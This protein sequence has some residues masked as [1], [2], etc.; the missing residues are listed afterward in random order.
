MRS[1]TLCRSAARR[2]SGVLILV[3]AFVAGGTTTSWAQVMIDFDTNGP[4]DGIQLADWFDFFGFEP[5]L[6]ATWDVVPNN[7]NPANGSLAL[8]TNSNGNQLIVQFS[9]V[10]I[11]KS[12]I[13]ESANPQVQVTI[14]WNDNDPTGV[15]LRA[16][17][18]T[19]G[20]DGEPQNFYWVN[21]WSEDNPGEVFLYKRRNGVDSQAQLYYIRSTRLPP[22]IS[23]PSLQL[24]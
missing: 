10:A 20:P 14:T 22:Q 1:T 15:Y 18:F 8:A 11:F 16:T 4:T 21:F 5:D 9:R 13:F 19:G 2:R 17:D 7:I 3:A 23:N 24:H 6:L 12:S